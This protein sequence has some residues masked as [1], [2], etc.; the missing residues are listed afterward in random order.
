[1]GESSLKNVD[2]KTLF[3]EVLRR[4]KCFK[5]PFGSTIFLGMPGTGKTTHSQEIS[6][7]NCWCYINPLDLIH[8]EP[9]TPEKS[10]EIIVKSVVDRIKQP[11]CSHGAVFDNFPQNMKQSIIFDKELQKF[12]IKID[13]V[14]ELKNSAES[15]LQRVHKQDEKNDVLEY[16]KMQGR[17]ISLDSSKDKDYVSSQLRSIFSKGVYNK[18]Q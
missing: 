8:T 13:R 5:R 15:F 14:V 4:Y 6:D 12:G 9:I 16:Y 10:D 18:T 2:N 1:M 3:A 11:I 7:L 17:V